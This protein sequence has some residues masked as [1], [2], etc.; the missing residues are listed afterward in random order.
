MCTYLIRLLFMIFILPLLS[1]RQLNFSIINYICMVLSLTKMLSHQ[2]KILICENRIIMLSF[3][4]ITLFLPLNHGYIFC[5][6]HIVSTRFTLYNYER[7]QL[8]SYFTSVYH[9]A[10]ELLGSHS[11][12]PH[13]NLT[14]HS[15]EG[16]TASSV[17]FALI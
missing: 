14:V 1:L 4:F 16:E 8:C 11:Q 17:S 6:W 2:Y 3:T 15:V 7:M 13:C 10:S 12:T 5:L 9:M